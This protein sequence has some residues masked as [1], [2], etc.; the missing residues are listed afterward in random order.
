MST[1]SPKLQAELCE[2]PKNQCLKKFCDFVYNFLGQ[3]EDNLEKI[4]DE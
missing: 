4:L 1:L 2:S 3:M